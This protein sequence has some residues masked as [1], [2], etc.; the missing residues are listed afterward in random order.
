MQPLLPSQ[1]LDGGEGPGWVTSWWIW[2]GAALTVF[3]LATLG[4]YLR[5]EGT[6]I[7]VWWPAAGF[8]A[9][10][11]LANPRH[12][13]WGAIT[14]IFVSTVLAN[15]V[16]GR[17]I[18][19]S[20]VFGIGNAAEAGMFVY[21]LELG[22]RRFV[23]RTV[24]DALRFIIA[25]VVG[26]CVIGVLAGLA[27]MTF[28]GGSFV[29]SGLHAA[30]SH[31]AAIMMIAPFAVLPPLTSERAPWGE[32]ALQSVLLLLSLVIVFG[33][34]NQLPLAFVPLAF[35]SW[36]AFRFPASIA[37]AEVLTT[38]IIVILVSVAGFG[39]FVDDSL[40]PD[41]QAAVIVTFLLVLAAFTLLLAGGRTEVILAGRAAQNAS[42]LLSSGFVDSQVALVL[43]DVVD[44][45]WV[46]RWTNRAAAAVLA[47]EVSAD[48]RWQ[49]ELADQAKAALECGDV[50]SF[51]RIA[52]RETINVVAN[53]VDGDGSR[54][55]VQIVDV[56]EAV[57]AADEQ[58]AAERERSAVLAAKIE[59]ERQREDFVAT[60]SHELRTPIVSVAGYTEMLQDSTELRGTERE[61]VDIIA[62]NAD[63]LIELVE[64]LLSLSRAAQA[65]YERGI[66]EQ[67][68]IAEIVQDVVRIQSPFAANR[69]VAL[70][71][72]ALDGSVTSVRS[73]LARAIGNL[74]S[75][76]IKFTPDGG[77][78]TIESFVTDAAT[79]IKVTDTGSGIP[80][81]ALAHVFERFY[82]A[83]DA[84]RNNTP[85]TGLGLAITAELVHRN[86]GTV[87]LES[88]EERGTIATV[89]FPIRTPTTTIDVIG[90]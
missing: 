64:G 33:V 70:Q 73:D 35:L 60:T 1:R 50:V 67:V 44:D 49:G 53:A 42:Q 18:D 54:I 59:L 58:L 30:M 82:R 68:Q 41:E 63:R 2:V 83:P 43:A 9:A 23:L 55:A 56:S 38:S 80:A 88:P 20:L 32:V 74:V 71:V 40:H 81:E 72:G 61:W 25:A 39:P 52:G 13:R 62:R 17:D 75:N 47:D 37:I 22:R 90:A 78:V 12:R 85:G 79:V 86:G 84:E 10:F 15:M 45:E 36:A 77:Q 29:T 28:D 34:E 27:I 46:V 11:V 24:S 14:L 19:I 69:G 89:R 4:V 31:S 51:Q 5:P 6:N 87:S 8:S 3:G 26:G 16:G 21:I 7:A 57:R 48:S 66:S 76:G 65:P